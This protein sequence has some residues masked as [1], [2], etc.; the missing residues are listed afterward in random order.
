MDDISASSIR[1]ARPPISTASPHEQRWM[2]A[3]PG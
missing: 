1:N 2:I 3:N